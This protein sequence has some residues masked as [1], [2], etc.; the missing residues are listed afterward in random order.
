[1]TG[2]S[3]APHAAFGRIV[4]SLIA[5]M[6]M[7]LV[8]VESQVRAPALTNA[9]DSAVR[10]FVESPVVPGVSVAVVRGGEVLLQRGYGFVDLEWGVRTPVSG[11]ASYEIGSVTKQFT[12]AAI[13]LLVEEGKIDLDA[14]FTHYID[15][16]SR[17]RVIPVRRLLD[18]TSGVRSYTDM[19]V[20][21]ALSISELPRDTLVRLVEAEPFDFEP[22]RAQIYNNSAFF[23]L[24]L[25]IESLSG[26]NYE[27]FVQRRL[28]DPAGMTESYYCDEVGIRE[29]RANGYDAVGPQ[30]LIRA[31][32]LN[33]Q[34]P[35]AAGSLCSTVAD[36]VRWN[37]ALH[38][39]LI[40]SDAS[41]REMTTARPLEN[42]MPIRYAMGISDAMRGR[43]PV[44]A[45]GGGINGFVSMLAWYPEH[46]LT[47]AVLQ[48][49]TAPPGAGTLAE[50]FAN[51]VLGPVPEPVAQR[52][53]GA[54]TELEGVYRGIARGQTMGVRI[55]V[56]DGRLQIF[57]EGEEK[58]AIPVY[59]GELTWVDRGT[60]Y[61]FQR[62][63]TGIAELRY[64]AGSAHYV[65]KRV[66]EVR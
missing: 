39:G 21:G 14:D 32:Y 59:I 44:H 1:M 28:F 36:L 60:H 56:I 40:L 30:Q 2:L 20:F 46:E 43:T 52:Y 38:G 4:V 17:G 12:A 62:S 55:R 34:W 26:Q 22:G 41:Y 61:I 15:F 49:S 25:I 57:R 18:H 58:P 42:G 8:G 64:T 54:L 23:I 37:R 13:L 16:N 65:L 5:F 51:L 6:S 66:S 19:S 63:D 10:S 9:L 48:N 35:Y 11:E 33:H 50:T 29:R 47:I 7:G 31:R 24:G 27:D 45:H 53:D 3:S